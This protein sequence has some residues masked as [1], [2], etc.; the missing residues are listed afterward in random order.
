MTIDVF[1]VA[2]LAFMNCLQLVFWSLVVHRLVNKIMSRNYGEYDLVKNGPAIEQKSAL[3]FS[4]YQE[5]MEE[6]EI[7]NDL[8]SMLPGA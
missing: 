5:M 8:N 7:L 6:K 3:S 4:E 2:S 1:V